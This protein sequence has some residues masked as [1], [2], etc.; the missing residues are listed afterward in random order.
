V[1]AFVISES[2]PFVK[3]VSLAI[4]FLY[5]SGYLNGLWFGFVKYVSRSF[6]RS[7]L[8]AVTAA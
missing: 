1:I 7:H 2:V 6:R 3:L 5:T 8:F 4:S